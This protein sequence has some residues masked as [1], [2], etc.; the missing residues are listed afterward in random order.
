MLFFFFV[1]GVALVVKTS[2]FVAIGDV[3]TSPPLYIFV[4]IIYNRIV[5]I[6]QFE[7]V[8]LFSKNLRGGFESP[9]FYFWVYLKYH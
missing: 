4:H 7:L 2:P 3:S 1:I 5:F 9:L 6:V 8:L